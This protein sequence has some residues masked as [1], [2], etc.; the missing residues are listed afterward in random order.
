M[1]T[2]QPTLEGIIYASILQGVSEWLPISSSGQV[3]LY[4]FNVLKLDP[5]NALDIALMLHLGTALSG[6]AYYARDLLGER[7]RE[8]FR[9]LAVSY[10]S[11]IAVAAPIYLYIIPNL[12]MYLDQVNIFIG[13]ALVA[14]GILLKKAGSRSLGPSHRGSGSHTPDTRSSIIYGVAQGIAILPGLSRSALTLFTLIYLGYRPSTAVKY[15]VLGGIP[16][17]LTA[18]VVS[19]YMGAGGPGS[20]IDPLTGAL[21]IGLTFLVGVSLIK[22][23]TVFSSRAS[24]YVFNIGF[25]LFIIALHVPLLLQLI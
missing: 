21:A 11:S 7:W 15:M 18:G 24:V 8:N 2:M 17:T 20:Y 10:A 22:F 25:G 19:L 6:L 3:V 9:F 1:K 14:S 4:L 13:V 5:R 23:L 16:A 12:T